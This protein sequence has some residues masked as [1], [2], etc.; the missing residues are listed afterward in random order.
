MKKHPPE[1][2]TAGKPE[3]FDDKL[4]RWSEEALTRLT[5]DTH[6]DFEELGKQIDEMPARFARED[7][8]KAEEEQNA[9][10]MLSCNEAL[11]KLLSYND[12]ELI[13]KPNK[14]ILFIHH[15]RTE[16][17]QMQECLEHIGVGRKASQFV[18][19]TAVELPILPNAEQVEGGTQGNAAELI[20]PYLEHVALPPV[21]QFR[22]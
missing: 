20:T 1:F 13:L 19:G 15:P 2:W 17:V 8:L 18:S 7:A 16:R 5:A 3:S 9:K 11:K 10:Q 21:R 4:T 6:R 14:T 12:A 22:R